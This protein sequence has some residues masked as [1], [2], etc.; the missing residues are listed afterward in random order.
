MDQ[1]HYHRPKH[2]QSAAYA[3]ALRTVTTNWKTVYAIYA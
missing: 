3:N 1:A 2:W